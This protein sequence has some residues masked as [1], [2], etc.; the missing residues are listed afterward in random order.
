MN[1]R[2]L[3][4]LGLAAGI[5]HALPKP[6]AMTYDPS[7]VRI[8]IGGHEVTGMAS[9]ERVGFARCWGQPMIDG[10][11]RTRSYNHMALHRSLD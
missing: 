2:E 6:K 1:R 4:K 3:F 11:Q 10:V 8:T 5:A 9:G 7:K